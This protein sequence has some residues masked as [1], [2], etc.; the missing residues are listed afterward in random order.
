M[1]A[2]LEPHF[3]S[4][5]LSSKL[6]TQ[7]SWGHGQSSFSDD[8]VRN[9]SFAST[10][11][12][13]LG[14]LH[15][16]LGG[17][18]RQVS[19]V[20][21]SPRDQGGDPIS[22]SLGSKSASPWHIALL[23]M[24]E[25]MTKELE[26]TAT[27]RML[28]SLEPDGHLVML[29]DSFNQEALQSF[30]LGKG[31]VDHDHVKE[32]CSSTACRQ[33][34]TKEKQQ[35]CSS[36]ACRQTKPKEK[37]QVCSSTACRQ[38]KQQTK[39]EQMQLDQARLQEGQLRHD[40]SSQQKLEQQHKYNNL[41]NNSLGTNK[42]SRGPACN[43]SSLGNNSL[44]IGDQ[45]ECKESLEQQPLAFQRSSLQMWKILIDTGAELSV[46]PW[47]FAAEIQLCCL[48][49]DLQLRAADGRA[50][51]IFG[52][53]TVQLLTPGFSFSMNFVIADVCQPLLG[54]G[55]LLRENLSLQLDK[56]LGHHL[57]NIA[58]EKVLLE[59]RGLQLYLS[60]CPA[61]LELTPCVRGSLLNDSLLPEAK[62]LGPKNMQLDKRMATQGGAIGS[63]LPLGTLRQHKQQRAK[64]AIGQQA[65][66]QARPKQKN[67]GQTKAS[68][69]E[70]EKTN[71]KEKMQLALLEPVDP[72]GSLDQDTAK[73]ISL[74]IFL[75]L[76]LMKKW[77]LK[78][79]RIQ[80]ALP[81]EL[82]STQ[83]RELGLRETQVDSHI[84]V[85]DQLCVFQHGETAG[86]FSP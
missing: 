6:A 15:N 19:W 50:I 81:Q 67:I 14:N 10:P 53:R 7:Q 25:C 28:T 80:T 31:L 20:S 71:F 82:T 83:L 1:V 9:P 57:G 16:S 61:H 44:G 84:L 51:G 69:L 29:L 48:N 78:I 18:G 58:G 66:P 41:G 72:R 47:D 74:R 37:Q 75:T 35:T 77:R 32:A 56:N 55:S 27:T 8:L 39:D 86:S 60:A 5:E 63:S 49:Q 3:T 34:K 42:K 79:T 13:N 26:L 70:L 11:P 36:T 52:V 40:L 30:E 33:T 64:T 62:S 23:A 21:P 54:L 73:D 12:T 46:A 17:V 24:E 85:G 2:M 68:K 38:T 4:V 65:L 43:N 59:Q 22:R 45:Q 76:S